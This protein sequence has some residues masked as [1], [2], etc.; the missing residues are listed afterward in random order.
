MQQ[1]KAARRAGIVEDMFKADDE[2]SF[3]PATSR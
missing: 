3:P 1:P 2:A